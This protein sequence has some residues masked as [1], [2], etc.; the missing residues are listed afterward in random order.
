MALA[1]GF[2]IAHTLRGVLGNL[3]LTPLYEIMNEIT[4]LLRDNTEMDYSVLLAKMWGEQNK[5]AALL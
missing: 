2:E 5:F 3:A 4:E 1:G